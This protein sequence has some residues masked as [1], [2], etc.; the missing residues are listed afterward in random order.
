M[1]IKQLTVFVENKQGALVSITDILALNNINLRA[2]SIAET[3]DFGILRLIVN[4]EKTAEK[5][6]TDAGYLIKVTDVVGV[7]IGDEPGKL[8]SA[9]SVLDKAGINMEYLYAFMART[10]KHAYVVL[11]VEDNAAAEE[12]LGDAGFHLITEA[13]IAKL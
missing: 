4:D 3:Q 8:T 1:A 10:E 11:R 6:L 13:D 7:K 5:T 9:L 2:L 12:A